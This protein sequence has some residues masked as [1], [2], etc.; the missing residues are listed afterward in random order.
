[1]GSHDLLIMLSRFVETLIEA[2]KIFLKKG[3]LIPSITL[4]FLLFSSTLFMSNIFSTKSSVADLVL[5]LTLLLVNGLT[6]GSPEFTN[7]AVSIK[8]DLGTIARLEWI[9][10][11]ASFLTSMFF[12]I[13]I[14][15]TSAA[16]YQE[17]SKGLHVKDLLLMVG[18]SWKRTFITFFYTILLDLGYFL[19]VFAFIFPLVLLFKFDASLSLLF[20]LVLLIAAAIFMIYISVVWTLSIIVSVLE[21]KS[22]IEALGRAS[23]LATKGLKLKGF[24]LKLVFAIFSYAMVKILMSFTDNNPTASQSVLVILIVLNIAWIVKMFSLTVFTVLYYD[25]KKNHGEEVTNELMETNVVYTK[26]AMTPPLTTADI[27]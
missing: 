11:V 12:A 16:T 17:G 18:K 7:L 26:I 27:P 13:A 6:P 23:Q 5:K 10:V 20:T 8:D 14:I 22:G 9:F 4:L 2:Y 15:I 21:E 25:C 1:M 3:K 19:F 24:C